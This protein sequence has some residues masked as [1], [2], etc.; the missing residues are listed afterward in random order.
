MDVGLGKN[1]QQKEQQSDHKDRPAMLKIESQLTVGGEGGG[2]ALTNEQ[3]FGA[4]KNFPP[5]R[6]HTVLSLLAG[7]NFRALFHSP[8]NNSVKAFVINR[9]DVLFQKKNISRSK[10]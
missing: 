6:K 4:R 2:R 3:S 1:L 5:A 10:A 7:R 9:S 8:S